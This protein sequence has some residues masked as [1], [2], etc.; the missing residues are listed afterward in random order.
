MPEN[1]SRLK[2]THDQQERDESNERPPCCDS[3]KHLKYAVNYTHGLP[4]EL[5]QAG[6]E[7]AA[8]WLEDYLAEAGEEYSLGGGWP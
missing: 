1:K 5:R 3:A 8:A 7:D 4:A 2:R 6:F